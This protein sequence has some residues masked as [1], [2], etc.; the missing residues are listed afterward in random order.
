M[1]LPSPSDNINYEKIIERLTKSLNLKD[2]LIA[3]LIGEW[4]SSLSQIKTALSLLESKQI[5]PEP[6]QRYLEVINRECDRQNSLIGGLLSLIELE[7]LTDKE[8]LAYVKLEDLVPGIV[9]TY[10]PLAQEKG[11]LL[12]YT[13]PNDL[14]PVSCPSNWIR[15]IILHLLNNS[16][17]FT[18]NG[19]KVFVQAGLKN[20]AIELSVTDTGIG[21]EPRDLPKIF[22]S[23]YRGRNTTSDKVAGAGLGLTVVQQLLQ[24]CGGRITVNSK[25]GKGSIFKLFLPI[26]RDATTP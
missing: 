11:I 10:Q 22:N 19:G 21:I 5:K 20:E 26:Y 15:Q 9:S 6:R 1:N 16:L 14:P 13:I 25:L 3:N 8:S 17:Q 4:R 18:A 12:G 7:T 2:E 24:R 23:F